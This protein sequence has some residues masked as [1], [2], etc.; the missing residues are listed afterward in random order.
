[1]NLNNKRIGILTAPISLS[2]STPT[3]NLVCIMQQLVNDVIVVTGNEGGARVKNNTGAEVLLISHRNGN[4][5]ISRIIRYSWLQLIVTINF[6]RLI[7]KVDVWFFFIGADT[8]VFPMLTTKILRKKAILISAGSSHTVAQANKDPFSKIIF[9]F[10]NITHFL[11][12]SIIYYSQ[13]NVD[14]YD[15]T[16]YKD[17]IMFAS[18]HCINTNKFYITIPWLNRTELIG[19]AGALTSS[20]GVPNLIKAIS[21]VLTQKPQASFIFAGAG[22]LASKLDNELIKL[23]ISKYASYVGWIDHD[24]LPAYLNKLKLLVLPSYS[25]GLPNIMLE[26]MACGTPV[27][28]TPVGAIPDYLIDGDTGFIMEDNSAECIAN[29]IIRVLNNPNIQTVANNAMEL[30]KREFTYLSAVKKYNF[31]LNNIFKNSNNK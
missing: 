4:D 31:I 6:L 20:K 2:G 12:N 11:S 3:L 17:K 14:E 22:E 5:T 18:E 10:K 8:M 30:V 21:A 16:K 27:L 15:F 29:N 9:Q 24:T 1:M 26:A 7:H 23:N 28:A 13:R 19:Y 25:E